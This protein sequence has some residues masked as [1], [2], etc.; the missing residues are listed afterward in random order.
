MNGFGI[1]SFGAVNAG[2]AIWERQ[3]QIF[4]INLVCFYLSGLFALFPAMCYVEP[5]LSEDAEPR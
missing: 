4:S 3:I 2:L 1:L 5:D